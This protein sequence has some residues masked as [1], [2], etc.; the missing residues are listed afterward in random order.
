[1]PEKT[2]KKIVY[3]AFC[4]SDANTGSKKKPLASIT[5]DL[6]VDPEDSTVFSSAGLIVGSVSINQ[7]NLILWDDVSIGQGEGR[8]SSYFTI[9]GEKIAANAAKYG[10]VYA[11]W[12][13]T[14]PTLVRRI[15]L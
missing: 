14:S 1:M 6:A 4:S 7:G 2:G 12:K 11:E 5:A 10:V 15:T 13:R 9:K 3:A 8:I